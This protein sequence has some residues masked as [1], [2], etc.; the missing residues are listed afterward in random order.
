MLSGLEMPW[1]PKLKDS[2]VVD[3]AYSQP[4]RVKGDKA[5]NPYLRPIRGEKKKSR[6]ENPW[7]SSGARKNTLKF[8]IHPNPSATTNRAESQFRKISPLVHIS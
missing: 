8:E 2:C 7:S 5:Q 6:K 4:P 3:Q 1:L